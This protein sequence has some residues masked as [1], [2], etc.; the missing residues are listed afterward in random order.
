MYTVMSYG[1]MIA[2]SPRR[3]AY[4]AALRTHVRP[5]S[6]VVDVGTGFGFFAV[7]AARLGAR[8]VYGVDTSEFI[9]VARDLAAANAVSERTTFVRGLVEDLVLS[10]PAD[11]VIGDLRGV[12][13]LH[14]GNVHAMAAA[15]KL[16]RPGGI[17]IPARDRLFLA[18]SDDT[19]AFAD[20]SSPWR[21]DPCG[22]SLR[23][24]HALARNEWGK[25]SVDVASLLAAPAQWATLDYAT[26]VPERVQAS[27]AVP[28]R[29]AGVLRGLAV[30]FDTELT[31][32]VGFSNAPGQPKLVYESGLFPLLGDA[33]VEPGQVLH[34]G[35]SATP[36]SG[37][38]DWSWT[39]RV[40][41]Q[42]GETVLEE[43]HHSMLARPL[44]PL[45]KALAPPRAGQ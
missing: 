19:R 45:I 37:D 36:A 40:A 7:L 18:A 41:G 33:G 39:V 1:S 44:A 23:S 43:R 8:H 16:L 13:P 32:N 12:L 26:A 4:E 31:Q 28:V 22:V 35:I 30:W 11:I 29:R 25:G 42:A 21:E 20:W 34:I 6:I 15:R 2:P 27:V 17:L 38:Y 24:V 14:E 10:S 3:D 9:H 5:H